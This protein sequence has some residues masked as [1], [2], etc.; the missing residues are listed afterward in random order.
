[1]LNESDQIFCLRTDL[2]NKEK[3]CR[4]VHTLVYEIVGYSTEQH[5][6]RT[7]RWKCQM[8]R[9]FSFPQ[10]SFEETP[11]LTFRIPFLIRLSFLHCSL[12]SV[13]CS[14]FESL[15]SPY[16]CAHIVC[17]CKYTGLMPLVV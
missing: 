8:A 9:L 5:N 3:L 6:S 13:R 11:E 16:I 17:K 12:I 10:K 15:T 14:G 2:N 1:M 4:V 7:K